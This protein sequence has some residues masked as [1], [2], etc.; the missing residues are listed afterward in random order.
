MN[1]RGFTLVEIIVCVS[2]VAVIGIAIGVNYDKIFGGE[3]T[4][5]EKI[6]TVES[7][8]EIFA[9][10]NPN[11]VEG[12]YDNTKWHVNITVGDLIDSGVLDENFKDENGNSYSRDTIIT[13]SLNSDGYLNFEVGVDTD[14]GY[15]NVRNSEDEMTVLPYGENFSCDYL[16]NNNDG[17]RFSDKD[18][19][20]INL[21]IPSK[22]SKLEVVSDGDYY[23]NISELENDSHLDS[24]VHE[25]TYTY[26]YEGLTRETVRKISVLEPIKLDEE[27]TISNINTNEKNMIFSGTENSYKVLIPNKS[28]ETF[29]LKNIVTSYDKYISETKESRKINLVYK[30]NNVEV[31]NI[32]SNNLIVGDNTIKIYAKTKIANPSQIIED[33]Y[34]NFGL[35]IEKAVEPKVT[36]VNY[37]FNNK[38]TTGTTWT[39]SKVVEV[40]TNISSDMIKSIQYSFDKKTWED[41]TNGIELRNPSQKIYFKVVDKL[42]QEYVDVNG[43]DYNV[44]QLLPAPTITSGTS[45]TYATSRTLKLTL[46]QKTASNVT[47]HYVL[48][49]TKPASNT[50]G[51]TFTSSSLTLDNSSFTGDKVKYIYLKTCNS[52]GCSDWKQGNVYLSKLVSDFKDSNCTTTNSTTCHYVGNKTSNYVKLGGKTWRIYKKVD[53]SL[54][55]VL[56]SSYTS[57]GYGQIGSCT[58]GCCNSGR[59]YYQNLAS[60]RTT[61][62]AGSYGFKYKTMNYVL[63]D[64][65]KTLTSTDRSLLASISQPITNDSGRS[66][67]LSRTNGISLLEKTDYSIVAGCSNNT[68]KYATTNYIKSGNSAF[69]LLETSTKVIVGSGTFNYGKNLAKTNNYVVNSNG[70]A[71]S[72]VSSSSEQGVKTVTTNT[73]AVRPIAKVISTAKILSGNGTSNNPYVL[74]K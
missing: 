58:S 26:Y 56:N 14:Y 28:T 54:Y 38:V 6:T 7:A 43:W 13:V 12:L 49:D 4:P 15:F 50:S 1:K 16:V 11:L 20:P 68:C 66:T 31:S 33:E 69:W 48:A 30:L 40:E 37:K 55:L 74:G 19:N 64:F 25:V 46:P 29:K 27:I 61:N 71:T 32:S 23:C 59:Y 67:T 39:T 42:N 52:V 53:N 62:S 47:Y 24:G 10:A 45:T 70:I 17:I 41:F 65:Y 2:I 22:A 63:D 21:N 72:V 60:T 9:E 18:G 51:K 34:V 57:T 3:K 73:Y 5:E 44:D 35:K 36:K 8:A